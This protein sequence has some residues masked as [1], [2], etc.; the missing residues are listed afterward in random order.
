MSL[1]AGLIVVCPLVLGV[2]ICG[3]YSCCCVKK[4]DAKDEEVN[5]DTKVQ[6]QL[7]GR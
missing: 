4:G 7:T 5:I 3:I 6:A 1:I 2:I